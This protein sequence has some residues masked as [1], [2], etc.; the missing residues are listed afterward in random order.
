MAIVRCAVDVGS[1]FM[2]AIEKAKLRDA[3]IRDRDGSGGKI[4]SFTLIM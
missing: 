3:R 2:V 1:M 4:D